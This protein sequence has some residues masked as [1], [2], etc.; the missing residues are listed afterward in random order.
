MDEIISFKFSN[1]SKL[2]DSNVYEYKVDKE[3]VIKMDF[4]DS[5]GF[6]AVHKN[7]NGRFI[8]KNS[9]KS[10]YRFSDRRFWAILFFIR[11]VKKKCQLCL[12]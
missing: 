8:R 1:G 6:V 11:R 9:P 10:R 5:N 7:N 3:G 2:L 12:L 4:P